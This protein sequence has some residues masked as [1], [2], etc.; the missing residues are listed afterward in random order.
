MKPTDNLVTLQ[1]LRSEHLALIAGN[2]IGC[3]TLIGPVLSS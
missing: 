2:W 3:V 1:K